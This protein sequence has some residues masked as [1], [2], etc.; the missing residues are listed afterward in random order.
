MIWLQSVAFQLTFCKTAL[1]ISCNFS[2]EMFNGR[3]KG[4]PAVSP[5]SLTNCAKIL[6]PSSMSLFKE[7]LNR[8]CF[9]DKEKYLHKYKN[10]ISCKVK[11][12]LLDNVCLV[13]DM[14]VLAM[15]LHRGPYPRKCCILWFDLH[16]VFPVVQPS[17]YLFCNL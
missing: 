1:Q 7:H 6:C 10:H 16:T 17:F 15:S 14:S 3:S 2:A 12:L 8:T 13:L 5:V 9:Q 4:V 11:A